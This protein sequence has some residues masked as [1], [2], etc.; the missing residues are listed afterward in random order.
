[1]ASQPA[2]PAG[3]PTRALLSVSDKAGLVDFATRL[4]KLGVELVST[5]GTSKAL[6]DAGLKVV[7]V[8]DLTQSPEMM[9]GRVKTLHPKVAGGI[10]A[11]RD[12]A[13][14]LAA[15]KQHGIPSIDVVCV[16]LYPFEATAAKRST[17]LHDLIEQVD[18]G[19]P[20][21]IRAAAK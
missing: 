12:N 16:N 20:S 14:D 4:A 6:R 15:M 21:L 1:M 3:T 10:L 8:S 9:D 13:Q 11:R 19:G 7:D 5:G 17:S 2:S 18:I